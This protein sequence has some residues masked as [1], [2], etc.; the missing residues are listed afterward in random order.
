MKVLL[1]N[2]PRFKGTPVVRE[3]RCAGMSPV[4]VYP[5]LRLLYVAAYLRASGVALDLIDANGEDLSF[6]QIKKI[7][8][9]KKPQVVIFTCSP[10]TM[11]YDC[12]VA[13]NAK[14]VN[15][16]IVTVLDDS[17][18]VPVY[19][20]KVLNKF[21]DIDILIRGESE[22]T[23]HLVIKN[24][25]SLDK[26]PG[27]SFR[28]GKKIIHQNEAS[29]VDIN[30]LPLPAYDLVNLDN[31]YSWTFG[32]AKRLATIL[33]SVSC[34]FKCSFCIV[35]G[36]TI[37]R[38]FGDKW[39][40]KT[41]NKVLEEI[42][43][44]YEKFNV[45]NFYFFDETFTINKQRVNDI[46][47]KIID[48]KMKINWSCNSRVDTVDFETLKHMRKS[49]CWNICFGLES[50]SQ[51]VLESINKNTDLKQAVSVFKAC[52]KFGIKTSAS[53][54]IGLP[55]D[56]EITLKETL[57]FAKKLNPDRVQFVIT[58]AY[59]GTYLYEQVKK[60]NLLEKEYDF[61]GFDAYGINNE[62]VLRTRYLS[63]SKISSTQK[64]MYLSFYLRLSQIMKLVFSIKSIDDLLYLVKLAKSL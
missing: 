33:T 39:R 58:T 47:N 14:E 34:P 29:P 51:K 17:H 23:S 40:S 53:F 37:W 2:P 30:S 57:L 42:K 35:G 26:V 44:L 38:G 15:K 36:A 60:E 4:S 10:T 56:N 62:A 52:E 8:K 45:C 18:I 22:E 7:I 9:E 25:K 59:P 3:V 49:G 28:I 61:S 32:K 31:Y 6:V 13:K 48:Y 54:M 50:G 41:P 12:E 63:A 55:E 11:A 21:A 19:P 43:Y 46:C 24:L 20:E 1:I 5:P 27:I 64:K 16:E